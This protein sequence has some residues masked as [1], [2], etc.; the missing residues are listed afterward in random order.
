MEV[1]ILNG[2][3]QIGKLAADAIEELLRR[4]PEAQSSQFGIRVMAIAPGGAVVHATQAAGS[5]TWGAPGSLGGWAQPGG[6]YKAAV[7]PGP[8]V[9]DALLHL[10]QPAQRPLVRHRVVVREG[11]QPDRRVH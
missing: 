4:K 9:V 1:V 10:G 8:R 2:S 7:P 11:V 3:K 6:P 5:D